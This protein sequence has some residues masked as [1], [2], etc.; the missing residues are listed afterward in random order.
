MSRIEKRIEK[1]RNPNFKQ[2]VPVDD[3]FS[4]LDK[5]FP[6]SYIYGGKRGSHIFKV[7]HKLLIGQIGYGPEGDF[8]I[9]TSGGKHVKHF[10]LKALVKTIDIIKEEEE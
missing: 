1:W 8:T 6:G 7:W 5:Y 9:P 2:N 3:L 4:V 10:Y